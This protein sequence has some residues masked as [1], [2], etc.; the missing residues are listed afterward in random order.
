MNTPPQTPGSIDVY[1][2]LEALINDGKAELIKHAIVN[3]DCQTGELKFETDP[4]YIHTLSFFNERG[5]GGGYPFR[6]M[7][8]ED[9]PVTYVRR[10]RKEYQRLLLNHYQDNGLDSTI[11]RYNLHLMSKKKSTHE[12]NAQ[13]MVQFLG[14]REGI[15]RKYGDEWY[16]WGRK[17][18]FACKAN[19]AKRG[20]ET[21]DGA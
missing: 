15:D 20:S 8:G 10:F 3:H 5:P 9:G 11:E 1:A 2:L 19:K 17:V 13:Y 14:L 21:L 12:Y 4:N 16:G 7:I 18:I 6:A